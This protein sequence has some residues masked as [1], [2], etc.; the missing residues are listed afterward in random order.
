MKP[1]TRFHFQTGDHRYVHDMVRVISQVN[2][3]LASCRLES[4]KIFVC[5]GEATA[6]GQMNPEW[7]KWLRVQRL[8]N[9]FYLHV[10]IHTR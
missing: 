6:V 9:L 8:A 1:V 2:D 5:H 10:V 4:D 3:K 7:P